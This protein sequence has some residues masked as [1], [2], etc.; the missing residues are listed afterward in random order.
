MRSQQDPYDQNTFV[1]PCC[2]AAYRSSFQQF[3]DVTITDFDNDQIQQFIQRWF[4]SKLDQEADSANEY[5]QLLQQPEN[6]AAKELAQTPLLLTFLYLIYERE[7]TLPNRRSPL[8][9]RALN[10]L[11]ATTIGITTPL[12]CR[13]ADRFS[14]NRSLRNT[15]APASDAAPLRIMPESTSPQ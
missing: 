9:G 11:S 5:W 3:S 10:I 8:Y 4:N 12:C 14:S 6:K 1:A 15:S 7:Q 13:L 2:T